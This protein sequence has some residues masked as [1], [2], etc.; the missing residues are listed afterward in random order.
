MVDAERLLKIYRKARARL[1][2]IENFKDAQDYAE[3]LSAAIAR[4][5]GDM[6]LTEATEEE[7]AAMLRPTLKEAQND[8]IRAA[9]LAQNAQNAAVRLN[10]GTLTA[11]ASTAAPLEIAEQ[12]AGKAVTKD[13]VEGLLSQK[14]IGSIDETERKNIEARDN[15]GLKVHIVRKYSDRGL[16]AGTKYAE[17]CQWCLSR[18]GEWDNYQAAK[19]AGCFERHPGCLCTIDYDTGKIHYAVRGRGAWWKKD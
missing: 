13:F 1:G 14:I 5:L 6:D 18:C 16:R 17:P 15:M 12:L 2:K 9:R 8:A 4:I 3:S 7:I 19:A 10:I 11:E